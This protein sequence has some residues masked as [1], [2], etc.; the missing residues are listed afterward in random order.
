MPQSINSFNFEVEFQTFKWNHEINILLQFII[1]LMFVY[2]FMG[3]KILLKAISQNFAVSL[4]K[5]NFV[6]FSFCSTVQSDLSNKR[7]YF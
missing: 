4:K 5:F 3:F 7:N 2:C 1:F 6:S